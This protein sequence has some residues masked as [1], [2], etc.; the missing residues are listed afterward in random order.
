MTNQKDEIMKFIE[1]IKQSLRNKGLND[2]EIK[3][4]I[5]NYYH[6]SFAILVSYL[7]M[8]TFIFMFRSTVPDTLVLVQVFIW[9]MVLL[10][11]FLLLK[12]GQQS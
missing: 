7:L 10:R 1:K 11:I 9:G 2:V 4:K 8:I 6:I 12:K 5:Q 3:S